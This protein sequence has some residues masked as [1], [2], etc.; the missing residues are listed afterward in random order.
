[1]DNHSAIPPDGPFDSRPQAEAAFADFAAAAARGRTGPP[2]E[3]ITYTMAQFLADAITDT[4]EDL[5]G[6]PGAYDRALITHLAGYLDP[7]EAATLISWI[8]RTRR[9]YPEMLP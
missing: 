7:V 9:D 4:I 1:M 5:D 3:E 2:G 6:P 8:R